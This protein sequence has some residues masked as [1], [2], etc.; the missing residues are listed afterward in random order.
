MS[1]REARFVDCALI[2][3]FGMLVGNWF[4]AMIQLLTNPHYPL[5]SILAVVVSSFAITMLCTMYRNLTEP[6]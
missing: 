5:A 1:P 2:T 6:K 3:I 4:G